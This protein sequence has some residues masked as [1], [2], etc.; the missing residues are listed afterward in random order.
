MVE[1]SLV[2]FLFHAAFHKKRRL[3][4]AKSCLNSCFVSESS[5]PLTPVGNVV[6]HKPVL[7]KSLCIP[8]STANHS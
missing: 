6:N 2:T 8:A 7:T 4:N 5:I 1:V 3:A